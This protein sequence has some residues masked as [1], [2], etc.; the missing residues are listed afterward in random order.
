MHA[1]E[2]P[3]VL[4]SLITKDN[5][6]QLEQAFDAKVTA[7]SLEVETEIVYADSDPIVQ[8]S[9]IIRAIQSDPSMRPHGII[10]EPAGASAFAEA[11]KAAAYAKIGWA[12][13]SRAADYIDDLRNLTRFPVF[14]ISADDME[15]G[16]IQG[17]QVNALLP[18]GG[19][20][21]WVEGPSVS[22]PALDRHGGFQETVNT[23]VQVSSVRGRWTEE[24]A[25]QSVRSWLALELAKRRMN[26]DLVVAQNDVMAMGTRRAIADSELQVQIPAIG[27][28][29]VLQTGQAWVR[30]GDLMA[31]VIVP[32]ST[33]FAIKLM[34]KAFR[35]GSE[36][37]KHSYMLPIP[38]P[39]I[40]VLKPLVRAESGDP[41]S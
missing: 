15:V 39:A 32:P 1:T 29:G 13:L 4:V 12:V 19:S 10:V 17:R 25:F 11:A 18:R 34:I 7:A 28:D 8:G 22:S 14:S 5:D 16:R 36:V 23:N 37:P 21:L 9:R 2:K 35:E 41:G 30:R 40:Q 6:Y 38:F 27:C 31:T 26:I 33:G 24:S 3:R 20:V